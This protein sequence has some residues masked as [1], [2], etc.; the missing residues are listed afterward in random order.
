[1]PILQ[2]LA[3]RDA[4]KRILKAA[5]PWPGQKLATGDKRAVVMGRESQAVGATAENLVDLSLRMYSHE[6]AWSATYPEVIFLGKGMARPT[7]KATPDRVI[8]L[9]ALG[10]R[11]LWLEIKT[12]KA[13]RLHTLT[14][15]VHQY[16]QMREFWEQGG[17]LGFYLVCWRPA[18]STSSGQADDWRLYDVL[19]LPFQGG[20]VFERLAG[21]AVPAPDGWPRWLPV[22]KNFLSLSKGNSS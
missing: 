8:S 21:L 19:S 18:H 10:G 7:G 17:A 5:E 4:S 15:R 12:W 1:M 13:V 2:W 22:F 11:L 9:K 3:Y 6:L 16:W 20:P 14:E